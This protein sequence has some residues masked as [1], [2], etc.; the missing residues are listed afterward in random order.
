ME[1]SVEVKVT[2]T[3]GDYEEL[4][5]DYALQDG[6]DPDSSATATNDY[7]FAAGTL[8]FAEGEV[9]QVVTINIVDDTTYEGDESFTISLSNLQ[10]VGES[11]IGSVATATITIQEDD[12]VPP[13][14]EIGLEFDTELVN[15]NDGSFEVS[16]VRT[17]GSFGEVSVSLA[18]QDDSAVATSDYEALSQTITF[19]DGQNRKNGHY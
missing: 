12:A 2:R 9:E 3:N 8:T 18:T 4:T 6:T 17:G 16:I 11:S 19:A 1:T 14:G 15:E 7:E 13:A 10:S 5:V